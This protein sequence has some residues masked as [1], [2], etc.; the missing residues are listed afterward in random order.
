MLRWLL[1]TLLLP[2]LL[3]PALL[4]LAVFSLAGGTPAHAGEQHGPYFENKRWGYKVRAPRNWKRRAIKLDEPWIADKFFPDYDLRA[5]NEA[6]EF[7]QHQPD[8]WIIGFPHAREEERVQVEKPDE[9]TTIITIRNPYKDYP[10]FVKR[11]SWAST[12]RGGWYFSKDEEI[13]HAGSKVHVYEIKVEKLVIAPLRIVTWLYQTEDC[14][15]AVQIRLLEEH[16]EEN[17][18]VIDGVVKSFRTIPR[19]EPF[20]ELDDSRPRIGDDTEGTRTID[21]IDAERFEKIT[22]RIEREIE[23]LPKGWR[24]DRSKHFVC[25]TQIDKTHT[26]Y[27]LNFAEEIRDYLED[28][29]KEL[30]PAAVPP[31]LIRV[32]T[33]ADDERAYTQ[34]TRG[35][36][37]DEVGEITMTYGAGASIL[38]EFS[39]LAG[40]LTDQ[41]FHI[42]NE[43]LENSMPGWIRAGIWGHIGWMRPSKRKKMMIVPSPSDVREILLMIKEDK[44]IPL[45]ELM[46]MSGEDAEGYGHVAQAKSVVYYLLSRG[47]RGAVKGGI[48]KYLLSLEEI[49]K[50]ED[51]KFEKAEEVRWKA[52]AEAR[53]Q[54]EEAEGNKTEAEREAEE[55]ERYRQRRE[56]KTEFNE[57]L[58]AKWAAIRERA[59]MAAFGHLSATDWEKLDKKWQA[60][61]SN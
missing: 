15:F 21:E 9:H 46:T 20:P 16:Y 27:V 31:G 47:D 36:W 29:F 37:T 25:L 38:G 51:E 53:R 18:N 7:V 19:T 61:A 13:E 42:K 34:G 11:E 49:L 60:F 30:G 32:F 28:H 2:A 33:S 56:H 4:V 35:W 17:K 40:R 23:H 39:W 45:R 14:D 54:Q 10:D 6:G 44:A 50:E 58:K 12:G 41:Y 43:N 48:T 52:D 3:L 59:Q 57:N 24:V 1:P 8:L 26:R 22:R 55:E 5:R